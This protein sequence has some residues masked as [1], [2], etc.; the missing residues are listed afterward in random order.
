MT[1]PD[2]APG[3]CATPW[4]SV[5]LAAL[6]AKGDGRGVVWS[7]A[8][9]RD[10]DSNLVRLPS[11]E[12][13]PEHVAEIDVLLLVVAGDGEIEVEGEPAPLRAGTLIFLPKG[14]RRHIAAGK[15]TLAY[16]T[17]HPRREGLRI[18][19]RPDRAGAPDGGGE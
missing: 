14:A 18:A 7:L 19:A 5:D 2:P 16:L 3:P 11:G 12:A 10:L 9:V 13:M 6:A 17:A 4:T 8:G 15:E 1:A